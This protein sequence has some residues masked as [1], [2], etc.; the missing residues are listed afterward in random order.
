MVTQYVTRNHIHFLKDENDLVI[1][2][3]DDLKSHSAQYFQNIL[4][5]TDL[6]ISMAP[7]DELQDLLPFCCSEIQQ[8]YLS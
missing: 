4:G 8:T 5:V 7:M 6:P 3:T 2:S 1:S